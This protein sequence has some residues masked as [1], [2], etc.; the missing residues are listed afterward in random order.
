MNK[1]NISIFTWKCYWY[2]WQEH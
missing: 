2:N 1:Q